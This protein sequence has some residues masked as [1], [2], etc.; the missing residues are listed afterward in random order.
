VRAFKGHFDEITD[1]KFKE[2][3]GPAFQL[4]AKTTDK[5]LVFGT[6]GKFYTIGCDKLP[7]AKGAG[8]PIRLMIGLEQKDEPVMMK[9]AEP[10]KRLLIA[11][12][13]GKGFVITEGDVMA[14]T[15]G[16][17]HILNPGAKGKAKVCVPADGDHV[18][19]IGTGRKLLVFPLDQIPEMKRGQGVTLQKYKG[20]TLSDA[21]VFTLAE[22]LSWKVGDRTRLEEDIT[23]WLGTRAGVGKL[24][25][26]GFPRTNLFGEG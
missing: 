12:E 6:D 26:V 13:Q 25:P 16:G 8:E 20:G 5:L 19:V 2:G 24:P 14:Q 10:Q 15:R 4:K 9:V 11:S 17:K 21:K 7:G 1:L 18:A 22:G 23:P 3:D